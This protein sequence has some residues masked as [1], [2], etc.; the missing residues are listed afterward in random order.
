MS[1]PTSVGH[2][3]YSL[4]PTDIDAFDSLAELALD[5]HSSWNHGADNTWAALTKCLNPS[6][7]RRSKTP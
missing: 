7:D 4:L 3:N 5:M 2:S 6:G 1:A